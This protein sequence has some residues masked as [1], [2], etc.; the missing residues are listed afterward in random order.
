[1]AN[2]VIAVFVVSVGPFILM[3]QLP[4]LLSRLFPFTR[5]LNHA[6]WAPNAWALVTAADRV[7]LQIV[8]RTGL[9][10]SLNA[11]GLASTSRG[12]V[13]DTVFAVLPNIKPIHTFA[14]TLIF[15]TIFLVKLWR[16]PTYKSFLAALTLCGYTSFMF[17]WHV[18]EKAILLVLVPLSLLACESYPYFR[19]FT[20]ASVAGVF[21]LFPLLFT[22]PEIF[23]EVIYSTLW[24][25]LVFVPLNRRMYEFPMSLP[26]VIVDLLEKVYLAGFPI[27]QL[28][29][30][31]IPILGS[32]TSRNQ[33]AAVAGTC[34]AGNISCPEPYPA[35]PNGSSGSSS[36]DFLPLMLT[37]VYCAVG[38]LWAF[39]RLSWIYLKHD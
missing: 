30:T 38:L 31:A 26:G 20:I 27:L 34:V 21:S 24:A 12:L 19:T 9:N 15:Q 23:V 28:V 16:T 3:G 14:I 5:G 13:G 32:R 7:L 29:V 8:K 39:L 33:Q 25:I 37:S 11:S 10:V 17:G 18:H 2:I 6:Y 4:Q 22:P 1:L 36:F 35:P